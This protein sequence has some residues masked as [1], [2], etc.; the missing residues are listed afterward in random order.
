MQSLTNG[1]I[2][3]NWLGPWILATGQLS[4][5]GCLREH[6]IQI[7]DLWCLLVPS[8]KVQ[9]A[10]L[11]TGKN[12]S[13]L[14][15]QTFS[16]GTILNSSNLLLQAYSCLQYQRCGILSLEAIEMSLVN[17]M[18][19]G[20]P[21]GLW[22]WVFVDWVCVYEMKPMEN[23]WVHA[24]NIKPQCWFQCLLQ[25]VPHWIFSTQNYKLLSTSFALSCTN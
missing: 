18:G 6:T 7:S 16:L 9:H 1:K 8:E 4:F 17:S 5:G 3:R 23:P 19:K 14:V 21:C 15:C 24:P 11:I 13:S 12:L 2:C 22:V 10:K 20:N 25:S